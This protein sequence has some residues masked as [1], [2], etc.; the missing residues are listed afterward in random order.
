MKF[1]F[2]SH[3]INKQLAG[4]LASLVQKPTNRCKILYITTP[5]NTYLPNPEWLMETL[6]QLESFGFKVD[7]FELENAYD[8]GLDLKIHFSKYD[9]VFVSGG[10]TFY[11]LSW[12]NKVG[13]KDAMKDFQKS[14]GVYAG[15]SAG[16]VCNFKDLTPIAWLDEP[17]KAPSPVKEGLQ[18]TD[19]IVIPH[20]E[21]PRYQEKLEKTKAYYEDRG[22]E[23]DV[24]RDYEGLFVDGTHK[25]IIRK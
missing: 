1:A 22:L 18:L 19:L 14:G 6:D 16:L 5:A 20:W 25:E 21:T 24:I 7:R 10:N 11:F 13:F 2:F 23:V 12:A 8:E 9:I 15:E 4:N 17:E 3:G